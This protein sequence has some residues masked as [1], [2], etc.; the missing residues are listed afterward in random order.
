MCLMQSH[1]ELAGPAVVPDMMYGTLDIFNPHNA[2]L[3]AATAAGTPCLLL[4]LSFAHSIWVRIILAISAYGECILLPIN[5]ECYA[6]PGQTGP[7]YA[8]LCCA[9][10]CCAVL[11][12]AVLCCAVLFP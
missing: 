9:V 2:K 8:V 4:N 7:C 6:I 5:F 11:C 3:L 1:L 12:C 10:L